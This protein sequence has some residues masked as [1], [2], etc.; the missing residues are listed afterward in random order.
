MLLEITYSTSYFTASFSSELFVAYPLVFFHLLR[1]ES[2]FENVKRILSYPS[3][4]FYFE[5]SSMRQIVFVQTFCSHA[6]NL[7]VMPGAL[8]V[9]LIRKQ[10]YSSRV[11]N[12][13]QLLDAILF[14]SIGI[15]DGC[16]SRMSIVFFINTLKLYICSTYL[17]SKLC[18]F[19]C[20]LYQIH[21]IVM[22]CLAMLFPCVFC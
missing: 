21:L 12:N 17:C 10:A 4:I 22:F 8:L 11:D 14:I 2:G 3:L 16:R 1:E 19:S 18:L 7:E 6:W 15:C 13:P 5:F 9:E 20:H